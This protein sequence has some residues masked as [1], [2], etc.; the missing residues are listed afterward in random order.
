MLALL[1]VAALSAP[2]GPEVV[3]ACEEA[4]LA[5]DVD[6]LQTCVETWVLADDEHPLTDYYGFYFATLAGRS[7][8]AEAARNRALARGLDEVRSREIKSMGLPPNRMLTV[9][10]VFLGVVLSLG[11][12]GMIWARIRSIRNAD[13]R[14]SA[15]DQRDG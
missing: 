8:A 9:Q 15:S 5:K 14:E 13:Q 10:R 4:R 12:G 6:G 2:V 11:I 3:A 7:T 1:V